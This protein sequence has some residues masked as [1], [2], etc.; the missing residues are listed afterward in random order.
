MMNNP[1]FSDY[2]TEYQS[3]GI[4][5]LIYG[6]VYHAVDQTVRHYPPGVYSINRVWDEDA[7]SGVCHDFIIDKLLKKGWLDYYLFSLNSADGLKRLLKRDF[8][9]FLISKKTRTEKTNL[10]VRVKNILK[11]NSQFSTQ[12]TNGTGRSIWGLA[13]W[14]QKEVTQDHHEVTIVMA[15]IQL[16]ALIRYRVDSQ[17]ISPLISN[18]DLLRLIEGTLFLLNKRTTMQVL[19]D[20]I[21]NRLGILT[22][23]II[24][25]DESIGD[26]DGSTILDIVSDSEA[27]V[28]S[29]VSSKQIAEDIYERLS[30]RQREILS[31]QFELQSPTLVDIG[32]RLGISKSTV[33]NE[34][35]I[36]ER[37]IQ[38]SQLDQLEFDDVILSLKHLFVTRHTNHRSI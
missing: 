18:P 6:L 17:K 28:E 10:Y 25:L 36:I 33:G 16:P 20:S 22:D 13:G 27:S 30:D 26:D 34:I 14:S 37:A 7:I 38:E 32:N 4:G 29:E 15:S 19:F 23:E 9:H 35:A 8:R 24:S 1:A 2:L 3:I 21:C 31:L 12:Q 5:P 11:N